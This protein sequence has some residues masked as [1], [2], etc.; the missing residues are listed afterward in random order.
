MPVVS[1][2]RSRVTA[3]V[4]EFNDAIFEVD[5]SSEP[6]KTWLDRAIIVYALEGRGKSTFL[7]SVVDA[8]GTDAIVALDM[9]HRLS[10]IGVPR[11]ELPDMSEYPEQ[12]RYAR[13][14]AWWD[15][16]IDR[17]EKHAAPFNANCRVIAMDTFNTFYDKIHEA[18]FVRHWFGKNVPREQWTYQFQ[19]YNQLYD[20]IF[21]RWSRML[22]LTEKGYTVIVNSHVKRTKRKIDGE[23][24]DMY[25]PA[26]PPALV[27][28]MNREAHCIFYLKASNGEGPNYFITTPLNDTIPAKDQTGRFPRRFWPT[29]A[30]YEAIMLGNEWRELKP[31]GLVFESKKKEDVK[32]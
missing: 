20:D 3:P 21:K 11:I 28:R 14:F 24:V 25:E 16:V 18:D 17:A 4:I 12:E 19:W 26:L 9:E 32:K 30:A 22:K 7:K 5:M 27:G 10:Q 8:W 13:Y 1:E 29:W 6:S 23:E 31:K 15:L 2:P